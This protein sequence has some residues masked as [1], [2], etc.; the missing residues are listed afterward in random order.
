MMAAINNSPN[1]CWRRRKAAA[2]YSRLCY[3]NDACLHRPGNR[4]LSPGATACLVARRRPFS[5]GY[6]YRNVLKYAPECELRCSV[7]LCVVVRTRRPF[8]PVM[9]GP[10][11]RS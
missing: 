6:M 5:S 7:V 3:A 9:S 10:P 4:R 2:L 8:L 1:P 11:V